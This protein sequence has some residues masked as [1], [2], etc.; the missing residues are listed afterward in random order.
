MALLISSNKHISLNQP[1]MNLSAVNT[2][3]H[4]MVEVLASVALHELVAVPLGPVLAHA[5]RQVVEALKV[6]EVH[7]VSD[8]GGGGVPGH[9]AVA[10]RGCWGQS[11]EWAW[12]TG[13]ACETY[14]Q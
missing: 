3:S 6:S 4:L 9:G 13:S 7:V 10:D 2:K 5:A 12:L 14:L 8:A 1:K 11:S